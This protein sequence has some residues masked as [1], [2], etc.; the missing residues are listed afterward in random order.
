VKG[1]RACDCSVVEAAGEPDENAANDDEAGHQG[2][3]T[4]LES[5]L[6]VIGPAAP[7]TMRVAANTSTTEAA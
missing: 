4:D 6:T 3:K 2:P 5:S 1:V 7:S